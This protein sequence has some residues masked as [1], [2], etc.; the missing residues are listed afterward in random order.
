MAGRKSLSK[1]A[2]KKSV[3]KSTKAGL[4]WPTR[5][6]AAKKATG[7]KVSTKACI[8]AAAANEYICAEIM[9]LCGN[10]A[11]DNKKNTGKTMYSPLCYFLPSYDLR[12]VSE[13]SFYLGLH[14][15]EVII[16]HLPS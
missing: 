9:E 1:V 2:R 12:R 16:T 3:T 5:K 8:M 4:Q 10:A 15:L 11:K 7:M 13:P 14:L 6:T